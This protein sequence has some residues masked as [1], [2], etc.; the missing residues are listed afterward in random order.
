[1]IHQA[2]NYLKSGASLSEAERVMI[3]VHGRGAS[4]QNIMGLSSYFAHPNM[5][6]LA[7]QATDS[8]WYP[9]SFLVPIEQN[10]PYL[11]SALSVLKSLVEQVQYNGIRT[12]NIYL[13]GFSQ[14]ACLS[15][16]FAARNANT[17]GGVFGL[18]GGLIGPPGTP[19]DYEG[20]LAGTS[21]FLGCS[22]VDAHIPKNRVLETAE[23]FKQMG[24]HVNAK[25]YPDMPHTIIEDE[26]K[27]IQH[28]LASKQPTQSAT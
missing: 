8:T 20:S 11:T 27:H 3:L 4:A 16:E 10:E 17:Y 21:V 13:L 6:F 15:L 9:Y 24:A 19:R 7:P 5:A 12:E 26:I 14:G 2:S 25:I 22:D 18:S 28:I 23:V 1:M